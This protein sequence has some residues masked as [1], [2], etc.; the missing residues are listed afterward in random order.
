M[1]VITSGLDWASGVGGL[2]GVSTPASA[3]TVLN[4]RGNTTFVLDEM[5][6][7][8]EIERAEQATIRHS[9]KV[10]WATGL[11]LISAFGRGAIMVDSGGNVTK[12]LSTSLKRMRS[13]IM[14]AEFTVIAEGLSFDNPPDEFSVDAHDQQPAL[15]K[16][17]RYSALTM[18]QRFLIRGAIDSSYTQGAQ[19]TVGAVLGSLADPTQKAQAIDLLMKFRRGN[20]S[21]YLPGFTVTWSQYAWSPWAVNPGGYIE[22][23]GVGGAVPYYF[24]YVN[25]TQTIFTQAASVNP[26]LYGS[27]IS[28]LRLADTQSWART[29]YKITRTWIGSPYGFWDPSLY[30]QLAT[31]PY[32]ALS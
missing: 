1:S 9:F 17:P 24:W 13:G 23:P 30:S 10:D 27:G 5:P 21:F 4:A 31:P 7:S 15:E 22:D 19:A 8:P 12:I 18:T 16:H 20:E 2:P 11:V 6:D 29:W 32:E 26:Q 25:S 28:W 14:Q 3:V